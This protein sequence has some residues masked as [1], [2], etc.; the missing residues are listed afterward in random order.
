MSSSISGTDRPPPDMPHATQVIPS[1]GL[2]GRPTTTPAPSEDNGGDTFP[3]AAIAMLAIVVG[4]AALVFAYRLY[5]WCYLRTRRAQAIEDF[6][7][8]DTRGLNSRSPGPGGFA[9]LPSQISL[10]GQ[11]QGG[12]AVD[13]MGRRSN[14]GFAGARHRQTSWGADSW[15][16][17]GAAHAGK[18]KMAEGGDFSPP[19]QH[20]S[21]EASPGPYDASSRTSL[22][23]FPSYSS[24]NSLGGLP[25]R[26]G[27]YSS[28]ASGSQILSPTRT[29][30]SFSSPYLGPSSSA[31]SQQFPSGNRLSGAPHS[32]H[33]R[34]EVIPPM[35]LAPPPGQVI[36]TDRS[37]LDFA[38]SS[39]IGRG[40][41]VFAAPTIAG[42][43]GSS[44]TAAAAATMAPPLMA[45]RSGSGSGPNSDEWDLV[46]GEE[47]QERLDPAFDTTSPYSPAAVSTGPSLSPI[48]PPSSPSSSSASSSTSLSQQARPPVPP[49]F[50]GLSSIA[51]AAPS[52]YYT[53]PASVHPTSDASS[54]PRSAAAAA[55]ARHPR[56]PSIDTGGAF[57]PATAV[58][59]L[60]DDESEAAE[61][62]PRSPLEKLQLQMERERKG[63]SLRQELTREEDVSANNDDDSH[64]DSRQ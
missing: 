47:A 37:T 50:A 24:R 42:P 28:S 16:G 35:P 59:H 48:I 33:S 57:V 15:A 39:G 52:S 6:Y 9:S 13:S 21:R 34:I 2:N 55:S 8:P 62:G 51:T 43:S 63:L 38:P 44:I 56:L 54:L 20:G 4:I 11:H 10:G 1:L 40:Q 53:A 18:E 19:Q 7:G 30:S 14:S 5:R 3:L 58:P 25:G 64:Y 41:T 17:A 23:G 22:G 45:S 32:V 46:S 12:M 61:S 27:I 26:R 49:T 60:A 36:A 31:I 29:M